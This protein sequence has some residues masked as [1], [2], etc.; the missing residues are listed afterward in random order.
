MPNLKIKTRDELI[1]ICGGLR[2]KGKRI[3]F[4]SGSFDLLHAGHVDYLQKARDAC[5]CL[6]VGL[7][8]DSSV[9]RYKGDNRPINPELQRLIV[10]TGLQ[11]V[12]YAF[13]FTERRNHENIRLLKPDIYF[14]AGDYKPEQLTSGDLVESYGGKV[15]LI[16][17]EYDTSTTQ[18]IEKLGQGAKTENSY[19]EEEPNIG[20]FHIRPEKSSPAIFLDRDG[21]I[22][23]DISYLHEPEK[24]QFLPG[25]VEGLKLFRQMGYRLIIITNQGGI[26][27]GYY[28]K[29]DFYN[30]NR[31]MMTLLSK[32][33]I[34]LDKIYFCPHSL[35]DNCQCRK[36]GTE[37]VLRAR[38]DLNLD[39]SNSY[40]IGDSWV[41]IEAAK[42]AGIVSILVTNQLPVD[43]SLLKIQ[44]DMV[45][46]NLQTASQIILTR[47][48]Q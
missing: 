15:V 31:R 27:L 5:D 43:L 38:D 10:I 45:T 32:E 36:P 37:L 47:E 24:F 21:T 23:P 28:T 9:K 44:P 34:M 8:T 39:L 40:F 6:I 46:D 22:N 13:L 11:S 29:E 16:P 19:R 7:N 2:D 1:P 14:K 20:H 25:V 48:R 17:I 4:T 41:D 42:A 12:D 3:G 30:V 18:I 26:G 33:G 35:A